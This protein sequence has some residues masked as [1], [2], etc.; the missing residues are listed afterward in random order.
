M[1][2]YKDP[3]ALPC[4]HSFCNSCLENLLPTQNKKR[5]GVENEIVQEKINTVETDLQR[6]IVLGVES[7]N[8]EAKSE[9]SGGCDILKCPLCQ[10]EHYVAQKGISGFRKNFHIQTLIDNLET[11]KDIISS[12]EATGKG[13]EYCGEHSERL[14]YYCKQSGCSMTICETCWS[15]KHENHSVML[16]SKWV[17]KCKDPAKNDISSCNGYIEA[18]TKEILNAKHSIEENYQTMSKA[19]EKI[20]KVLLD[21]ITDK[22]KMEKEYCKVEDLKIHLALIIR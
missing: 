20:K 18:Y 16:L 19:E 21:I 9:K 7:K 22:D 11:D 13:G 2:T 12:E 17:E 6:K 15:T 3:R 4:L 5:N 10:E 8:E 1:E 14:H